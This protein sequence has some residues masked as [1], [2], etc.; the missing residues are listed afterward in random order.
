MITVT[1]H[2]IGRGKR[3]WSEQLQQ[4]PTEPVLVRLVR[5]SGALMS[6]DISCS[7]DERG[8]CGYVF[9]GIHTVGSFTIEVQP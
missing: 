2:S 4:Q 5:K 8:T 9:A 6:R 1:F 7:L 3:T